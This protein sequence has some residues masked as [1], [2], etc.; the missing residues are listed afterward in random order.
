MLHVCPRTQPASRP[1][2]AAREHT[3]FREMGMAPT[4]CLFLLPPLTETV[5]RSV[6]SLAG[7]DRVQKSAGARILGPNTVCSRRSTAFV[8]PQHIERRRP[9]I[10]FQDLPAHLRPEPRDRATDTPPDECVATGGRS[11]QDRASQV[12]ARPGRSSLFAQQDIN[13]QR[14]QALSPT[15]SADMRLRGNLDWGGGTEA[16]PDGTRYVPPDHEGY[17]PA[18]GCDGPLGPP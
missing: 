4:I 7:R 3:P 5:T 1:G 15:G 17:S 18:I 14:C 16:Q 8:V 9:C 12:E 10:R 11:T 13:G 6:Q 2:A